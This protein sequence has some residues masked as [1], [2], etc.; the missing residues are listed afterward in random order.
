MPNKSTLAC[1]N[2]SWHLHV[3]NPLDPVNS[4]LRVPFTC[5]SWRH[6]GPCRLWKGS[7][8]FARVKD[9]LAALGNWT[10]TVWTF[11]QG[12]W[13]DKWKQYR[14][15]VEIWAKL[16]KRLTRRFGPLKYIQTWERHKKGGAHV[17]VIISC[18]AFYRYVRDDCEQGVNR[19]LGRIAE[20]VGFG[21]RTWAETLSG[22]GQA[23][24]GYLTKLSREMTGA[25]AKNQVPED[26]PPH[27]RR[28]RASHHTLPPVHKS[29]WTGR[30]VQCSIESIELSELS[31]KIE[32]SLKARKAKVLRDSIK[33]VMGEHRGGGGC[34]RGL[35]RGRDE[36]ACSLGQSR[37]RAHA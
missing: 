34:G 11:A 32:N 17:N 20:Q 8:D 31:E 3:W 2:G 36:Y 7:Q 35:S 30:L 1:E 24:A 16:R 10:Y 19:D 12:D 9:A 21:W 29:G 22:D 27:F 25:G 13:P 26:A 28:L 18:R 33:G 23:M 6:E 37:V 5:R 4:S 14:A 15:G